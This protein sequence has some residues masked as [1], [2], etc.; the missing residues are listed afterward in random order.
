MSKCSELPLRSILD[1]GFFGLGIISMIEST[2]KAILYESRTAN[3]RNMCTKVQ[4][5]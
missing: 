5:G 2:Q 3:V 1:I 4:K